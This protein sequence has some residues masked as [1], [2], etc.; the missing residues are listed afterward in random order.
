[1]KRVFN[2][3]RVRMAC[4]LLTGLPKNRWIGQ[5]PN[6]GGQLKWTA[7]VMDD[8]GILQGYCIDNVFEKDVK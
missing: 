5:Y 7:G 6:Y 1:M 4:F 8:R 3:I 2:K